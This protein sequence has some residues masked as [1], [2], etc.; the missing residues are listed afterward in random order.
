MQDITFPDTEVK[1]LWPAI[2]KDIQAEVKE[3]DTVKIPFEKRTREVLK[4][5]LGAERIKTDP[6]Y[7]KF[8]YDALRFAIS[9]HTDKILYRIEYGRKLFGEAGSK[10]RIS[11]EFNN[12]DDI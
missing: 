5:H 6:G 4:K 8:F 11:T 3:P 9:I 7:K 1:K 10:G 12:F 2:Y